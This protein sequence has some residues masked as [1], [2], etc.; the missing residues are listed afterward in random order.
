MVSDQFTYFEAERRH[1]KSRQYMGIFS[2]RKA[3]SWLAGRWGEAGNTSRM[4]E[5]EILQENDG[6]C[7]DFSQSALLSP[8][9][10]AA[11]LLENGEIPAPE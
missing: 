8:V 7:S 1:K 5:Q 11:A 9:L 3:Q 2:A 10:L 6:F 4:L